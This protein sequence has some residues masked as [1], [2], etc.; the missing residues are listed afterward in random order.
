MFAFE[1][2]PV[3]ANPSRPRGNQNRK[4]GGDDHRGAGKPGRWRLERAHAVV[5]SL[6]A[7]R[8]RCTEQEGAHMTRVA[9]VIMVAVASLVASAAR[10]DDWPEY[11]GQG[12]KGE[13]TETG[14]LQRF[15][16]EGLKVLWR[17]PLREGYSSPVVANGRVFITDFTRLKGDR[18]TE[19]A[20][21]VDERTGE[22]L[23][24]AE[25][26]ADYGGFM[27][28]NGPRATPTVDG[29]RVY[30]LGAKG[31]LQ[32][33]DVAT[34]TVLWKRDYIAEYKVGNNGTGAAS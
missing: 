29:E 8:Y 19:R 28:P 4:S 15:P 22:V 27:W 30:V 25:W 18:G 31:L 33:F 12:R 9:L 5:L 11:R 20:L 10:A 26:A 17:T 23:W 34:G 16:P 1:G 32:C 6:R 3:L 7:A 21:A 2:G 13:W 24:T 14:V